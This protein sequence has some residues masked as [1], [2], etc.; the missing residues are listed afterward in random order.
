M[1]ANSVLFCVRIKKIKSILNEDKKN[2]I[3]SMWGLFFAV[4]FIFSR[5]CAF[6]KLNECQTQNSKK[7]DTRRKGTGE[8]V[9]TDVYIWKIRKSV[10]NASNNTARYFL[11]S[12]LLFNV[13]KLYAH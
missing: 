11:L 5:F 1:T 3:K 7:D 12:S 13:H 9:K 10:Q 2:C 4:I 8:M 6:F